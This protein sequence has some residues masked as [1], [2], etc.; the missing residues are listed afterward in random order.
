MHPKDSGL[1]LSEAVFNR[2][3]AL[4]PLVGYALLLFALIDSVV[5][6]IP[7]QPLNPVW[8]LET[9]G[10]MVEGA[11]VW[12]VGLVFVFYGRLG[13]VERWELQLWR[14]LSWVGLLLGLFYLLMVPVG[15]RT[16][17][18]IYQ[19]HQ[20]EFNAQM[21]QQV[22][23]F[24]RVRNHLEQSQTLAELREWADWVFPQVP[25]SLSTDREELK[26]QLRR[27]LIQAE[28]LWESELKAQTATKS[29]LLWKQSVK[30]HLGALVGGVSFLWIWG[31]TR[32]TRH[33]RSR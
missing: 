3:L 22:Q 23:E 27:E 33:F 20:L 26:T 30:W 8:V 18:S 25:L 6:W 28:M 4:L 10:Q 1:F 21:A 31:K 7:P 14:C 12:L 9:M 13:Y 17:W 29:V 32:W 2:T 19:R 16:T 5:L 15:V 24:Q 11:W